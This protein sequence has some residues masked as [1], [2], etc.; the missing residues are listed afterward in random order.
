MVRWTN[1][2]MV[3]CMDVWLGGWSN[4]RNDGRIDGR[5]IRWT[6]GGRN[7][8]TDGRMN[9]W[10]DYI[11]IQLHSSISPFYTWPS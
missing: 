6:H 8:L 11:W 2:L 10:I 1:A 3:G 9:S 4:G 7:G 5:S